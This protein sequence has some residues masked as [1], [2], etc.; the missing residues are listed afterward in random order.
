MN[1][2]DTAWMLVATISASRLKA[3]SSDGSLG[4]RRIRASWRAA[5]CRSRLARSPCNVVAH[6]LIR[7]T[8]GWI[9]GHSYLR[10]DQVSFNGTVYTARTDILDKTTDPAT[11]TAEWAGNATA[12]IGDVSVGT[13]G[14]VGGIT[15]SATDNVVSVCAKLGL[16]ADEVRAGLAEQA[17]KDRTRSEV[18][19]A[20]ATGAFGSPYI[21]ID[22]EPFWGSDRL[23]QI[24]K[25]LATGGW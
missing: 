22:G 12:T 13:G 15:V 25:W 17:T 24:E 9:S 23:D 2:A 11:N 10:G 20:I 1:A 19:G 21:I 8:D 7:L 18:D 14:T 6:S 5:A 4:S 16:K 3:R